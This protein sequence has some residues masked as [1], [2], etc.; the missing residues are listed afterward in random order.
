MEERNYELVKFIDGDFELE[1]NVS[2]KE[3]TIWLSQKEIADLFGKDRKTITNH[4]INIIKDLELLE[5]QVCSKFE[6][7]AQDG[8]VYMI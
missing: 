3:E 5:N 1:V 4:I 8:K 6:H 7:T 2:P